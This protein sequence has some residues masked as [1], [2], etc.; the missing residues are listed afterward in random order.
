M[1]IKDLYHRFVED[2]LRATRDDWDNLSDNVFYLN[3]SASNYADW[4]LSRAKQQD[5]S[6]LEMAAHNSFED[7]R[8]ACHSLDE[9]FQYRFRNGICAI[10][11]TIKHGNPT[12]KEKEERWA[13]K[14]G[15]NVKRI[16]EWVK[17]HDNCGDVEFPIKK[18]W[19]S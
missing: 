18:G 12:K 19:L 5:L 16:R 4:E 9:C 6:A 2:R 7:C 11:H 14:S 10:S 8:R 1:R 15:W 13:Y 17:A 3:S